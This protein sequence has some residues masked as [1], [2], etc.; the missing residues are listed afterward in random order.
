M[1][2]Y[3]STRENFVVS[4]EMISLQERYF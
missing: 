2:E 1:L 3:Q 4:R